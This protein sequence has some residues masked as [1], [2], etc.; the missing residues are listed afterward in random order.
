[1]KSK[2]LLAFSLLAAGAIN[3]QPVFNSCSTHPAYGSH[4]TIQVEQTDTNGVKGGP[5]GANVTW[6]FSGLITKAGT[7]DTSYYLN[8]TSCPGNSNFPT[9]TYASHATGSTYTYFA[10]YADSI[11]VVGDYLSATNYAFYSKPSKISVCPFSYGTSFKTGWKATVVNGTSNDNQT[12]KGMTKYDAYGTLKTPVGTFKNVART[13]Q[14]S[15]TVDSVFGFALITDDS[16]FSWSDSA[17]N[18][19]LSVTYTYLVTSGVH[20]KSAL[21]YLACGAAGIAGVTSQADKIV[22]YPNPSNGN[23][24]MQV[25][26]LSNE[27]WLSLYNVTG[28]KVWNTHTQ[29]IGSV[30]MPV[31]NLAAGVYFLKV[32]SAD[33]NTITKKVEVVK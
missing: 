10:N 19:L 9:A 26:G 7:C 12:S 25:T 21:V 31:S 23:S 1:M 28:Q 22:V 20:S 14:T 18:P 15:Y 16:T 2:L 3:A 27:N 4:T 29:S 24:T 17:G 8:P 5:S 13:L 33:G 30:D 11:L 32:Q 6:D